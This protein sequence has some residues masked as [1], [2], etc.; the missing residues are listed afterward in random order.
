MKRIVAILICLAISLS[1][2]GCGSKDD[3]KSSD[4]TTNK[5]TKEVK[6]NFT[7]NKYGL[8]FLAPGDYIFSYDSKPEIK[9]LYLKLDDNIA[10]QV[11]II[12]KNSDTE[13]DDSQTKKIGDFE[14]VYNEDLEDYEQ[15]VLDTENNTIEFRFSKNDESHLS[16]IVLESL[17]IDDEVAE[18]LFKPTEP[19]TK[20]TTT[21]TTIEVTTTPTTETVSSLSDEELE[22]LL[23]SIQADSQ[24][25]LK[26]DVDKEQKLEMDSA[27]FGLATS[28]LMFEMFSESKYFND[29]IDSAY[30]FSE[31]TAA[32]SMMASLIGDYTDYSPIFKASGE[33]MGI[34]ML[35]KD[36]YSDEDVYR[37]YEL[38]KEMLEVAH[39]EFL[40]R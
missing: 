2:L 36:Y 16:S 17:E 39:P 20:A 13:S 8:K 38:C 4:E 26:E 3:D 29:M 40:K 33:I 7:C 22:T 19:T 21:P 27:A 10:M 32:Y 12:E 24:S 11:E 28:I 15:Y 14:F 25:K 30:D 34:Q 5:S 23:E 1:L 35:T 18:A 31:K 37:I 6:E 9:T